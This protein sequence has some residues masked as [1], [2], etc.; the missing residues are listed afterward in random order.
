[1]PTFRQLAFLEQICP[2]RNLNLEI[3]KNNVGIRIS[4][5]EIPC[6]PIFRQNEQICP[7]L[8]KNQFRGQN[9]KNLS[10]DSESASLRHNVHQFSD[11]MDNFEF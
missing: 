8:P 4:I 9:F 5:L 1:M 10:L 11:K 3:H 7:N 2:K 6:V